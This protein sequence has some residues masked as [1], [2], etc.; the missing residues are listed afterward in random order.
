MLITGESGVGKEYVAHLIH[1]GSARAME[2]MTPVNCALFAGNAGLANSVLFGHRKG[3]FT[4][5]AK[6]RDGAFV[7]A[8]GG[9][10][11]LDEVGELPAAVQAKFLRVLE[12]GW[13]TPEGADKP[14]RQVDVRIIAATNR[15]LACAIRAGQFRADLYHRLDTLRIDVPPLREH[16]EDLRPI[17]AGVGDLA[18]QDIGRLESYDWPGNVRQL[19]K[20][21]RRAACL[22]MSVADAIEQERRLGAL[23]PVEVGEGGERSLLPNVADDLRPLRDVQRDYALRALELCDG[24][25]AAAARRLDIAINTLRSYAKRA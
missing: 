13:V 6:D 18:E 17:V 3:A 16:I 2:P 12:D 4:G 22:D 7:A 1:E 5:A 11:F 15:D 19:F 8:D 21:L 23:T 24:V 25:Y 10:L 20:V 14:V 9:T